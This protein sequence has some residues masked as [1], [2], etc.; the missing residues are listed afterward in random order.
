MPDTAHSRAL[1]LQEITTR[2]DTAR[3]IIAGFTTAI[4]TLAGLWQLIDSALADT[5]TLTAEITHL[6]AEL[7]GA[8]RDRANVLAAARA[9]L[10]AASDGE[11]DPLSYIRDELESHGQLP[12]YLRGRA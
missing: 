4:P 9:T 10:A 2:N 3:R 8:R 12:P 6:W 5:T 1:D 7:T 11:R